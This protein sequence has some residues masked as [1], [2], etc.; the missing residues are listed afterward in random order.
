M[1]TNIS[2][3]HNESDQSGF[4]SSRRVKDQVIL[5]LKNDG[6]VGNTKF[7][8]LYAQE[9]TTTRGTSLASSQYQADLSNSYIASKKKNITL[10][11]RLGYRQSAGAQDTSAFNIDERVVWQHKEDLKSE[12]SLRYDTSK[13]E[14]FERDTAAIGVALSAV[15]VQN[16][17][18]T[19]SASGSSSKSTAFRENL[20]MASLGLN[21]KTQI[22]GARV[23][24]SSKHSFKLTDRSEEAELEQV[25]DQA[26]IVTNDRINI[27]AALSNEHID[28]DSIVVK[29]LPAPG[30]VPF[31]KDQD[32]RL[33]EIGNSV[34]VSCVIGGAIDVPGGTC[35][36]G[37]TVYVDYKFRENPFFNFSMFSQS[38]SVNATL[39]SV[40]RIYYSYSQ[41]DQQFISGIPPDELSSSAVHTL[42]T[43]LKWK[44]SKTKMEYKDKESTNIPSES[45]RIN[46]T[47]SFRPSQRTFFSASGKYST[48]KLKDT[49]DRSQSYGLD[50]GFQW[51]PLGNLN[52]RISAS[53]GRSFGSISETVRNEFSSFAQWFYG[54]WSATLRY[55][56]SSESDT[57][58]NE[59]T[60][61]Q[62]V[63]FK[64]SRRLY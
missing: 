29:D 49:G 3:R 45:F 21:Y 19:V 30:G 59:E 62:L 35:S 18:S 36:G 41:S 28:I 61:R 57:E 9:E 6:F 20:Y 27:N 64:L 16:L 12:Y 58:T 14:D 55:D 56:F 38:Y 34:I 5:R 1:P 37:A 15:P 7:Y 50:S 11:S 10:G 25:F 26:V 31:V 43:E 51:A 2:Y 46:E 24:L 17:R 4:F 54:I 53:H 8:T 22:S 13:F 40:W 44:W 39:W 47:I 52:L 32:Y 60:E 63:S 33:T 48:L 23:N 42:G